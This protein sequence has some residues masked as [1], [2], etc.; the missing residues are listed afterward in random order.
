M[1]VRYASHI[2]RK[3]TPQSEPIPGEKQ[4]KNNAGGYVYEVDKW[5][6]LT[7]F[8]VL[9]TDGGTFY[10]KEREL[11]RDNAQVVEACLTEDP[12][13]TLAEIVAV[14]DSG[15]A[16]KN[17]P[18]I[19]ALAIAA[20]NHSPATRAKALY[21][22]LPRVCRIPTHLFHFMTYVRALRG[23]S[24]M[25]R[26]A[27]AQ[28][29]GRWPV[30][31]L[32]FECVKYQSRDGWAN[33]DVFRLTHPKMSAGH[34]A[35][36]RWVLGLPVYEDRTVR[37]KNQPSHIEA[38]RYLAPPQGTL[39]TIIDA[40]EAA[41][42]ADTKQLCALIREHGLTREMVPTTALNTPEVWTALLERMPLTA[43]IRNLGKM[44]AIDLLKPLSAETK[45]VVATLGN[46][47]VLT[48]A[49][50]HPLMILN[51]LRVYNAGH[52]DRG[53]LTWKPTTS[54]IDALDRAF[55]AS[56]KN[57]TPTGK[58]LML[59]LDVS[60]SMGAPIAGTGLDCRTAC[61]AMAL[62]T[63]NVEPHYAIYG[64]T[65]GRT[66]YSISSYG[67]RQIAELKISPKQRLDDVVRYMAGLDFGATDCALPM[68]CAANEK[69]VVDAFC[70]YTDSETWA[71]SVHPSQALKQ[72]RSKMGRPWAKQVVIGMTA[73]G[74][75]IA[76]PKDPLTLDVVGFDTA[77][78]EAISSFIAG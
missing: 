25:L 4:A 56:F 61:A 29:Y 51:A 16:L 45:H 57:V 70:V 66:G 36:L 19:L 43:M 48:K 52:G 34:Q 27:V 68:L 18:A 3:S 42:T 23:S 71:G 54:I 5:A 20:A 10:V 14:S 50:V 41:K 62:V 72:Y 65:S 47:E 74:F 8:L 44:T 2:N 28:W 60:G 30:D 39:P 21:D 33:R 1:T 12:Y 64:F 53:S 67:R 11:T 32:A 63:A 15:R 6:R 59:A 49:R 58:S 76:D 78:P 26:N 46:A 22:A 73:T 77:T 40:F 38:S 69:L 31:K 75:T 55:Y 9:G 37:R 35:T 17:D 7:R 13:R 24:R